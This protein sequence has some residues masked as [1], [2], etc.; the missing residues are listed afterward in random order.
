[1]IDFFTVMAAKLT[2]C[3]TSLAVPTLEQFDPVSFRVIQPGEVAI[4]G[5]LAFIDREAHLGQVL[6]KGIEVV[7]HPRDLAMPPIVAEGVL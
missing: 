1:M 4:R 3:A 5:L 7:D 2:R 6:H